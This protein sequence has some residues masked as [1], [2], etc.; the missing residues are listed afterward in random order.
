MR[1]NL[2]ESLLAAAIGGILGFLALWLREM[3][4]IFSGAMALVLAAFYIS[5]N[6]RASVGWLLLAAGAVPALI[7]G[8]SGLQA[9]VDPAIQ[10][11]VDTWGMLAV[12]VAVGAPAGSSCTL[13]RRASSQVAIPDHWLKA[14]YSA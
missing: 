4:W 1:R 3:G 10:V 7:L 5:R 6:R 2:G 12:A 13:L 14:A 11:G 8:R 9:I